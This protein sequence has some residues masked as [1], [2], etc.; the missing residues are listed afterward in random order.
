MCEL[1]IEMTF[2]YD[3]NS[4][5]SKDISYRF[6]VRIT[7]NSSIAVLQMLTHAH[8]QAKLIKNREMTD[9]NYSGRLYECK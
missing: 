6:N 5:T 8:A 7:Q 9:G 1:R 3:P 4:L 2:S